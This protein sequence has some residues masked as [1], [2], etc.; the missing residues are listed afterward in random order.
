MKNFDFKFDDEKYDFQKLKPLF[1]NPYNLDDEDIKEFFDI[2]CI[3]ELTD[4]IKFSF[5]RMDSF[6]YHR[7]ENYPIDVYNAYMNHDLGFKIQCNNEMRYYISDL[8]M[9]IILSACKTL[10]ITYE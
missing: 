9:N 2:L 10:G 1:K 8:T 6:I 4:K 7:K 5:V 3:S